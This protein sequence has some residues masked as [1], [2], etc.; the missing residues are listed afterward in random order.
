MG[1]SR[2][3]HLCKG[4]ALPTLTLLRKVGDLWLSYNAGKLAGGA[5]CTEQGM[6]EELT[7][8]RWKTAAGQAA[9]RTLAARWLST[10][11]ELRTAREE[12]RTLHASVAID[13][14]ALRKAAQRVH[15]LEQLHGVLAREL[16]EPTHG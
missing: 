2:Q 10:I 12:Y 3:Q 4:K 11:E 1:Y 13:V 15:D 7:P 6:S 8:G 9:R 14:R 5:F 16:G